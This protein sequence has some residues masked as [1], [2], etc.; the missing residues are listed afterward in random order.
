SSPKLQLASALASLP[1]FC[2]RHGV[3]HPPQ[4]DDDAGHRSNE[5]ILSRLVRADLWARLWLVFQLALSNKSPL[6]RMVHDLRGARHTLCNSQERASS[7][8]HAFYIRD[9]ASVCVS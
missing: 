9:S 7:V 4:A 1:D 8:L 2:N 5:A 6:G 3:V